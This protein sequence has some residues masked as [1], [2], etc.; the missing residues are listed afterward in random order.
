MLHRTSQLWCRGVG[1]N[2]SHSSLHSFFRLPFERAIFRI[3]IIAQSEK[4]RGPQLQATLGSLMSPLGKFN[5]SN[6]LRFHPVHVLGVDGPCKRTLLGFNFL[7][8]LEDLFQH[9][10]VEACSSMAH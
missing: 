4:Y 5:F 9:G 2:V 6:P 7:K 8:S 1:C 10:L 3:L